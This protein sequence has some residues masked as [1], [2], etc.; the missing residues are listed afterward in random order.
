MIKPEYLLS[1]LCVTS[2]ASLIM[3]TGLSSSSPRL[4]IESSKETDIDETVTYKNLIKQRFNLVRFRKSGV[5]HHVGNCFTW[6]TTPDGTV[7]TLDSEDSDVENTPTISPFEQKNTVWNEDG[8]AWFTRSILDQII[9]IIQSQ[10]IE[11]SVLGLSI[12]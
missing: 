11:I 8:D 1:L 5:S 9:G 4:S 2:L 7:S 3:L 12:K 6:V 10:L